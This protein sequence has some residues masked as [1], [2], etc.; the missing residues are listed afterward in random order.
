MISIFII[1][2]E[3]FLYLILKRNLHY[4]LLMFMLILLECYLSMIMN[5]I[6]AHEIMKFFQTK[7]HNFLLFGEEFIVK[8]VEPQF[9]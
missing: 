1:T 6:F 9:S 4:H 8:M 2:F 7:F 3:F 5:K